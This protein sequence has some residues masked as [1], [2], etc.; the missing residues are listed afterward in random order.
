MTLLK[1]VCCCQFLGYGDDANKFPLD[2]YI[3]VEVVKIRGSFVHYNWT[4]DDGQYAHVYDEDYVAHKYADV[5]KLSTHSI[6][7]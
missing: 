5:G 2:H 3:V 4:F 7:N 1:I 6:K